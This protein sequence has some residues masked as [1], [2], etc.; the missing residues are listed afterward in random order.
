[1]KKKN[2]G[3]ILFGLAGM[4]LLSILYLLTVIPYFF[5]QRDIPAK[6]RKISITAGLVTSIVVSIILVCVGL[7]LIIKY[8]EE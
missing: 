6:V 4:E 5:E 3:F 2:V 7:I 1:M 8:R